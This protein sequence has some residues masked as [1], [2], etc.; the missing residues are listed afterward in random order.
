MRRTFSVLTIALVVVAAGAVAGSAATPTPP[1][2]KQQ[3]AQKILDSRALLTG[4]ARAALEMVAHANQHFDQNSAQARGP[5]AKLSQGGDAPGAK[6]F[7]NVAVSNPAED[8]HE[9][10]QTTQSETSIAV[11]GL[12][13]AVGF[14]DSQTTGLFLTSGSNISGYSYS[15]DGGQTFTDGGAV[16]QTPGTNNFGDPWLASDSNGNMYYAQLVLNLADELDNNRF[17]LDVG[18]SRS[19]DGGKTWT[20]PVLASNRLASPGGFYLGDKDAMAVGPAPSGRGTN[21]YV[22]WDDQAF[23]PSTG[24]FYL[25]LPVAHSSDGGNTWTVSYADKLTPGPGCSFAQY[26]GAQPI[27]AKDGTL[28]V[29]AEKISVD[30]PNCTGAPVQFSEYSFKSGDG[31]QTFGAGVKIA[32]VTSSTPNPICSCFKLGPGMYMRNLEFPSLAFAR[33]ALYATWNDGGDGSGHSHVR[34]AQSTDGG[35]TWSTSFVTSGNNDE[36]QPVASGDTAGLHIL[37]YQRNRDNTLDVNISNSTGGGFTKARVTS[38]SFPGV[39]NFPNFDPIIAW[40]YMGDYIANVTDGKNQYFAWGDN[41]NLVTNFLYP[42]GR[43]DPD[44]FFAKQ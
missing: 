3:I 32:D 4:Q 38:Q 5:A 31:G 1:P 18:V 33:N 44:V 39:L 24:Q 21:L 17:G 25:G 43:H 20:A 23:D 8:T 28:Y 11:S 40:T 13:V 9:L 42:Q 35:Q 29:A 7:T 14:N 22:A 36:I 6:Q 37:Y 26:I 41:R 34:L 2:T 15:T 10:D 19:S 30:D 12:N 16:P 27:V